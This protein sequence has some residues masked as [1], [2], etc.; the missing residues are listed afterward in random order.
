LTPI[1]TEF[2]VI[3]PFNRLLD[4]A[5]SVQLVQCTNGMSQWQ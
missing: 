1:F 2:S 3:L 5:V 4:L